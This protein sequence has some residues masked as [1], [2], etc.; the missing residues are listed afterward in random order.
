MAPVLSCRVRI[1]CLSITFADV[2]QYSCLIPGQEMSRD[3]G[4][5]VDTILKHWR[6]LRDN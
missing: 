3:V 5:A 2:H 6:G 4:T 1:S